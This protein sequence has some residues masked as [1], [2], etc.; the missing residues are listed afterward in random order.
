VRLFVKASKEKQGFGYVESGEIREVTPSRQD[1]D[2]TQWKELNIK[3]TLETS[4][5]QA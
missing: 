2:Q 1:C 5:T 4:S 3:Q